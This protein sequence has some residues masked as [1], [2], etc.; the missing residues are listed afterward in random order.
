MYTIY[1]DPGHAWLKVRRVE[2][3]HLRIL[4]KISTYSYQL[5]DRYVFLEEDCDLPIFLKA[6]CDNNTEEMKDFMY[7]VTESVCNAASPIRK[8]ECFKP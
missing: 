8:Y 1:S 2:L 5:G 6:K 7:N 3:S 4:D